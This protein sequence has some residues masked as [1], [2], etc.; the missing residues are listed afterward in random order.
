MDLNAVRSK[1]KPKSFLLSAKTNFRFFFKEF[2][3]LIHT[4]IVF[5]EQTKKW[6]RNSCWCNCVGYISIFLYLLFWL[7]FFWICVCFFIHVEAAFHRKDSHLSRIDY[8]SDTFFF[9]FFTSILHRSWSTHIEFVLEERKVSMNVRKSPSKKRS[10]N[11]IPPGI[12]LDSSLTSIEWL[13]NMQI[14]EGST[15]TSIP[16]TTTTNLNSNS[17]KSSL[18]VISNTPH[19]L[20]AVDVEIN[21]TQ[22]HDETA[23]K[24]PFS[25]VTL[26]RQAILNNPAQRMTLNEIYQWIIEN[27]PYFRTAPPKWKVISNLN[28]S[29]G[30]DLLKNSQK[31][32]SSVGHYLS[33]FHFVPVRTKFWLF[34]NIRKLQYSLKIFHCY[35]YT[36][37]IWKISI[38]S[39]LDVVICLKGKRTRTKRTNVDDY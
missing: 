33:A 20:E 35:S 12:P 22:N 28:I 21:P 24:P 37:L 11:A 38:D 14:G 25:Y 31:E 39:I 4:S 2:F 29:F 16:P 18:P 9:C 36:N 19:K 3:E 30:F 26:I 5:T 10:T 23:T 7:L 34:F 13:P 6:I 1:K 32:R 8:F 17:N 27:Y 15:T